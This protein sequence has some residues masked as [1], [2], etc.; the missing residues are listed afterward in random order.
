MTRKIHYSRWENI[1]YANCKMIIN[2]LSRRSLPYHMHECGYKGYPESVVF[3][4]WC[5]GRVH[6]TMNIDGNLFLKL[7]N[8]ENGNITLDMIL[9]YMQIGN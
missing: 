2:I 1:K 8:R 5:G 4:G 9:F 3:V 7:D 6:I